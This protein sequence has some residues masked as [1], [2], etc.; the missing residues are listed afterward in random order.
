LQEL[1][2]MSDAQNDRII[3]SLAAIFSATGSSLDKAL[4]HS[5]QILAWAKLSAAEA[6]PPGLRLDPEVAADA[7]MAQNILTELGDLAPAMRDAFPRDVRVDSPA[8]HSALDKAC[9]FMELGLLDGL[10][11]TDAAFLVQPLGGE[12][13]LPG[14]LVALM[15]KL[16]GIQTSD[17]VY[18]PWDFGGQFA[19]RAAKL[20]ARVL[21]EVP[22]V[23]PISSLVSLLSPTHFEVHRG[24]P[25]RFPTLVKSGALEK[26]DVAFA[27]PPFGLRYD[28]DIAKRDVFGRFPEATSSGT[29]LSIR[30]LLALTRRRIVVAVT[31]NVLFSGGAELALRRDLLRHGLLRAVIALPHGLLNHTNIPFNLLVIE[32]RGGHEVVRFVN[33]DAPQFAEKGSTTKNRLTNIDDLVALAAS[34]AETTEAKS[35]SVSQILQNDGQLQVGRYVLPDQARQLK[36]LLSRSEVAALGDLVSTVRPMITSSRQ[37]NIDHHAEDLIAVCEVGAA[38]L[39]TMG[40]IRAAGRQQQIPAEIANK[41]KDQFLRADDIVLIIKGSVGKVGIVPQEAPP[42]GLGGWVAGQS[43]IVLRVNETSKIEAKVLTLMLRSPFGQELLKSISSGA[44][45]PLIQLK[46][47]LRLQVPV[48]DAV[49]AEE[50]RSALEGEAEIQSE[51]DFLQH[52]QASLAKSLWPL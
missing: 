49:T 35:V 37:S 36:A 27:L 51:I 1:I 17:E 47:L 12:F 46:E 33:A 52:K 31:G 10:D 11:A 34:D 2:D 4:E 16:G 8:L 30:H 20:A 42:P 32:P 41:N 13:G 24:D 15:V 3:T 50:A 5:L 7:R 25:V 23:S 22:S 9:R 39:P 40:Y 28:P 45:I 19:A 43:G 21:V 14:P 18:C 38:D 48:P 26:F 6:I 29:I 44:T